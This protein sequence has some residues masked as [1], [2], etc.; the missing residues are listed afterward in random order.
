MRGISTKRQER[1]NSVLCR[2]RCLLF[3]SPRLRPNHNQTAY[4]SQDRRQYKPCNPFIRRYSALAVAHRAIPGRAP[5]PRSPSPSLGGVGPLR[6]A[7]LLYPLL[8]TDDR[9]VDANN[10]E[11]PLILMDTA[12]RQPRWIKAVRAGRTKRVSAKLS[13]WHSALE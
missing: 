7:R 8:R 4:T 5:F 9:L 3:S 11:R 13:K 10:G 1:I 12:A 6:S 2:S